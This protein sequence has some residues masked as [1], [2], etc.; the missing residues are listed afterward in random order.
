MDIGTE[1]EAH[2]FGE[3]EGGRWIFWMWMWT[4]WM[5]RVIDGRE[6]RRE[7]NGWKSGNSVVLNRGGDLVDLPQG[8]MTGR[9]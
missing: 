8:Q 2:R 6:E 4:E 3:G 9:R 7:I 1:E 5:R